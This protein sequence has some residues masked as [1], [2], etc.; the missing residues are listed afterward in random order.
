VSLWV[1][2]HIDAGNLWDIGADGAAGICTAFDTTIRCPATG[3]VTFEWRGDPD[4]VLGD[5]VVVVSPGESARSWVLAR[6]ALR[7]VETAALRPEVVNADVVRDQFVRTSDNPVEAPSA[8]QFGA[9]LALVD[10]PDRLL[11]R[12]LP[13]ALVPWLRHTAQDPMPPGAPPL[14]P[15]GLLTELSRDPDLTVRRRLASRLRDLRDSPE[16]GREAVEVLLELADDGGGVQRAA[17]ASLA[18]R[19]RDGTSAG[20]E[21]WKMARERLNDRGAPGRAAVKTLIAL[22]DELEPGPE[23]DPAEAIRTCA[24][25]HPER[26]WALWNAWRE[27]VPLD[28]QLALR[29]FR[30]TVGW[31]PPLLQYWGRKFPEQLIGVFHAFETGDP[32][33]TRYQE[34]WSALAN[35]ADPRFDD[36]APADKLSAPRPAPGGR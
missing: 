19:T 18:T 14:V 4:Y 31:S 30:G 21:T 13:D 9:L 22:S 33:S 2:V 10:H 5:G 25:V 20:L 11:R 32:H 29:L 3:P 15:V 8:E 16:L 35:V 26:T 34:L 7:A 24:V 23:V 17:L 6:A 28:T 1:G 27:H 36:L 12:E